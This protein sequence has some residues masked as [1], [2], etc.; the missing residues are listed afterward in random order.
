VAQLSKLPA[1]WG[2]LLTT[3]ATS[4]ALVAIGLSG[5]VSARTTANAVARSLALDASFAVK[6]AVRWA[7]PD[8]ETLA[9]VLQNMQEQ[10]L[11][12]IAV[13]DDDGRVMA[14]AGTPDPTLDLERAER[15]TSGP[16]VQT[17]SNAD[18]FR[19]TM[20][21]G[22]G[23]GPPWAG[24]GRGMRAGFGRRWAQMRLVVEQESN[25]SRAL[26]RRAES[27]LAMGFLASAVLVSAAIFFWR[28]SRQAERAAA[29]LERDR[30][31]TMLGE[32]SAVLGHEIRNPLASLKGHAQLLLEQIP[33]D[34]ATR[35]GAETVVREAVRL[36]TLAGQVL[37]FVRTGTVE[38]KI[39]DPV[40]LA[41]DAADSLDDAHV[42]L[43][44]PEAVPPW[45]LDRARMQQVLV[46]LL[47]NARDA[48]AKSAEVELW[49]G[50][51]GGSALVFEVRDRGEGLAAG[52]AARIFEP[53]YSRRSQGAGLGLA[54][55][56]RIVE[57]HGGRIEAASREGGG[58]VFRVVLV[59]GGA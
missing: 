19:V 47:R 50:I 27:T 18:R 6:H 24:P 20:L 2:L 16:V 59:S 48:C 49:V 53:F 40:A 31:L 15:P 35:E 7:D 28:T 11:R 54:I 22:E 23:L 52:D 26:I 46:N 8:A 43:T 30:R 17:V 55:A 42:T 4:I 1:R 10:G 14:S 33:K 21:L 25:A 32:M 13:L 9:G 3:I 5:Y 36:E 38:R 12:Y 57:E 58:A 37:D 44:A 34:G 51:E 39:E 29:Q 56:R 45:S 41:R